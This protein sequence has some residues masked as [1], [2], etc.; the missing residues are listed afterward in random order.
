MSN[1]TRELKPTEAFGDPRYH[2]RA[3]EFQ[4]FGTLAKSNPAATRRTGAAG[5][6]RAPESVAGRYHYSSGFVQE[7]AL[8]GFRPDF[9]P[10]TSGLYDKHYGEQAELVDTDC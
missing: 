4:A 8:A 5:N 3:P 2:Q 6:D 7:I 9:L 1:K 10:T